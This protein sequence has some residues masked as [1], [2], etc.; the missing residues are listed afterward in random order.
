VENYK[1]KDLFL[2]I[3]DQGFFCYTK[4]YFNSRLMGFFFNSR[5]GVD[6][7]YLSNK[8]SRIFFL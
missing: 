1:F 6:F 8:F 5:L 2:V 4:K 7:S 3:Q